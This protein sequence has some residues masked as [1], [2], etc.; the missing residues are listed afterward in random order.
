MYSF[1]GPAR[2]SAEAFGKAE[3]LREGELDCGTRGR[4]C[5]IVAYEDTRPAN[6]LRENA[7]MASA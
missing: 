2:L 4:L 7:T 5:Y 1:G 3:A 6:S